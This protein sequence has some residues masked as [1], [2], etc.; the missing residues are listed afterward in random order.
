MC[1]A[2]GEIFV[3]VGDNYPRARFLTGDQEVRSKQEIRRSG[4]ALS[5]SLPFS[6]DAANLL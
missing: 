4:A 5:S 3:G 1:A 2:I 6:C